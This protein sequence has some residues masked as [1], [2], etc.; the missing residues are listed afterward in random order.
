MNPKKMNF[1]EVNIGE[2]CNKCN[3]LIWD[4][5]EK[6]WRC[7]LRPNTI[8]FKDSIISNF[9]VCDYYNKDIK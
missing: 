4:K 1:R 2:C 8:H 7:K 6:R 3:N 5:I 9:Y